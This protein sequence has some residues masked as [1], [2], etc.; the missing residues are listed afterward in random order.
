MKLWSCSSVQEAAVAL[1]LPEPPFICSR[2]FLFTTGSQGFRLDQFANQS[3]SEILLAVWPGTKPS[4][5]LLEDET[6]VS[7]KLLCNRK[8]SGPQSPD[9][10]C[11][12]M[13]WWNTGSKPSLTGTFRIELQQHELFS[14]LLPDRDLNLSFVPNPWLNC[15]SM[16]RLW[17]LISRSWSLLKLRL[18]LVSS[19]SESWFLDILQ[20]MQNIFSWN[21]EFTVAAMDYFSMLVIPLIEW[22]DKTVPS[23]CKKGTRRA[24]ATLV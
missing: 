10:L 5:L 12:P 3:N 6:R 15:W 9:R 17:Q 14:I 20:V 4:S 18:G 24:G 11:W 2:I 7:M 19:P 23:L 1:N 16:P 21:L 22:L 13:T 8:Q